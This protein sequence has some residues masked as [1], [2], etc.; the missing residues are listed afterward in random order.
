M[1]LTRRLFA[2][3]AVLLTVSPAA[4]PQKKATDWARTVTATPEGGFRMGNPNARVKLVEYGSLTCPHCRQF[5]Q[6]AMTPLK[7]YVRG[8]KVSFEYRNFVLNGIDVAAALVAR[9][10]G[11]SR[12]FPVVDRLYATHNEW[13]GKISGLPE[14]DKEKIRAL[15]EGQRLVRLADVGG[16]QKLAAAYGLP[17]AQA[18]KCLAD[19]AGMDRLGAIHETAQALGVQGTPTFFINGA[20]VDA[21]DWQS[22]EPHLKRAGG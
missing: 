13:V 4:A 12:F 11:P 15:S 14:G 5:A 3:A 19:P 6:S 17:T 8:G 20:K 18:N 22:L 9:C 2:A 7:T 1:K 10:A 21:G 16:I